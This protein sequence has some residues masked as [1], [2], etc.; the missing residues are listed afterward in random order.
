[1]SDP[2]RDILRANQEKLDDAQ[3]AADDVSDA[4]NETNAR[5]AEL[6]TEV[7]Q[8]A[9]QTGVS[10]ST[11]NAS[12]PA[13]EPS[14]TPV[15]R[16]RRG[17]LAGSDDAVTDFVET[18]AAFTAALEADRAFL[19]ERGIHGDS[20]D[21]LL[22]RD[23]QDQ[24]SE[25][26]DRPVAAERMNREDWIT[27]GVA[28]GF[29]VTAVLLDDLVDNR[30]K[31]ALGSLTD[32]NSTLG[33]SEFGKAIRRW[34]RDGK[35]LAIDFDRQKIGGGMG[36][37]R[38]RSAGHDLLRPLS[39]IEQIRSGTFT[40]HR[41]ENKVKIPIRETMRDPGG[42]PF[43]Q[44]RDVYGDNGALMLW[45]KHLSADFC[46]PQSLPIPGWTFFHDVP[47][48]TV[49]SF[50]A[51]SYKAGL[52]LRRL[53][54]TG[55][56]TVAAIEVV[57]RASVY[58]RTFFETHGKTGAGSIRLTPERRW[59]M[60]NMLLAG[61]GIVAAT[62]AGKVAVEW[63]ASGPAA[64]RHINIPTLLML[65]RYAV[66]VMTRVATRNSQAAKFARNERELTS[67]WETLLAEP[68]GFG[69]SIDAFAELPAADIGLC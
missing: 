42:T 39:A 61:H 35:N 29:G 50:A 6:A 37:H 62:C 49:R 18:D 66:P 41:W 8:L 54:V 32:R 65:T 24:I 38:A 26:L 28:A 1:M 19:S 56:I 5:A 53:I 13:S 14:P 45:F 11:T 7:E 47:N 9:A 33:G 64:L 16:L 40:G 44:V 52:N 69:Q 4:Q 27:L 22:D 25:N 20:W 51:E 3:A 63:T 59:K 23:T 43:R 58:G 34:D 67:G 21:D 46:T 36:V 48:H 10:L 57:I 30:A 15:T 55:I 12:S 60:E 31:S 17:R 68:A 2:Y